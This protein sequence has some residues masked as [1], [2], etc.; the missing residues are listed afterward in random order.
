[1]ERSIEKSK[2]TRESIGLLL[3][4]LYSVIK[5]GEKFSLIKFIGSAN[6]PIPHISK[7]LKD[8]GIIENVGGN[9]TA[10]IWKWIPASPPNDILIE[11]LYN[12]YAKELEQYRNEMKR[13]SDAHKGINREESG[14]PVVVNKSSG[15][16]SIFIQERLAALED[17]ERH[18]IDL[19]ET[20]CHNLGLRE[21]LGGRKIG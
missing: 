11:K 19:L 6:L 18:I 7:G 5:S 13:R 15:T 21:S 1:M 3:Y 17:R 8:L 4:G 14:K 16:P 10:A 9:S 2:V 12:F 20:L